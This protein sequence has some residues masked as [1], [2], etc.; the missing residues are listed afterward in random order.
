MH[1]WSFKVLEFLISVNAMCDLGYSEDQVEMVLK[2][3]NSNQE[4]VIF[5]FLSVLI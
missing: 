2:E 1:I 3:N 4:K 5:K